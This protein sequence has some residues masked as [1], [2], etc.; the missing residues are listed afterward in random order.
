MSILDDLIKGLK[1]TRSKN[2]DFLI[3]NRIHENNQFI[4]KKN[5]YVRFIYLFL[6]FFMVKN[7]RYSLRNQDF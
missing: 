6:I 3:G 2:I 1:N 5:F 7:K 4:Y